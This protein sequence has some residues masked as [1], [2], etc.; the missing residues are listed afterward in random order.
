MWVEETKN[1]KYK[2][3]ERYEDY[4]TGQIKRVSVTLEKNTAQSRKT[5]QKAL[6]EKI[7]GIMRKTFVKT[8]DIVL[9]DLVEQ[10]R[11][12]QQL[13][14]KESTYTRNCFQCKT[15]V[16]IL[17]ENTLVNRMTSRYVRDKFLATGKAP[18]T[19]NE[20][21]VRF[22]ALIRWGYRNDLIADVSFL[23]K[24][25]PFQDTPHKLKI[26]DKYLET[27]ELKSLLNIIDIEKWKLL[28]EFLALSG[29][30]FGEAAALHK[31]DVDFKNKIIKVTKTYNEINDVVTSPKNLPS[32][33]DI[34]MQDELE[35][36]CRKI[37]ACML[38]Q[39]LM[40]GYEASQ[41]FLTSEDGSHVKYY[42]YNKYLKEKALKATEKVITPHALRHTHASLLLEQG[43]SIDTISRRLGHDNSKVTKEIYLH[44]T[45]KLK[46]KDNEQLSN[47]KI[48]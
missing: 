36:V 33:R 5:A 1:G 18:G 45:E 35:S 37:N 28:T 17:G 3:V 40:D 27:D 7:D 19:L 39:R 16:S 38:R 9:K 32:V 30:R 20:H 44:V 24:L 15:I 26:Q 41:L 47:I 46:E 10:Y 22:K 2:F 34:Y 31:T 48:L 29:L 21:L 4:L 8:N 13:T 6:D 43:I 11:K 25:K 12:D 23:D 42:T 14:V